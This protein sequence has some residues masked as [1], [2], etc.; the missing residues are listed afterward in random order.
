MDPHLSDKTYVYKMASSIQTHIGW[1]RVFVGYLTIKNSTISRN[2]QTA[3]ALLS[4]YTKMAGTKRVNKNT[5]NN[6]ISDGLKK[7]SQLWQ[8]LKTPGMV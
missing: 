1:W 8:S 4:I 5:K 2:G 6:I 7:T 3:L